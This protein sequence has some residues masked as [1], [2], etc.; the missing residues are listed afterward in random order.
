VQ[1]FKEQQTTRKG[2]IEER[3]DIEAITSLLNQWGLLENIIAVTKHTVWS[4]ADEISSR[5]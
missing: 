4:L 2:T 5:A 1:D 3:K